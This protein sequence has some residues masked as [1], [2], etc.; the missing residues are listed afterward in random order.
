VDVALKQRPPEGRVELDELT[1]ERA[2]RG[3]RAAFRALVFHHQRAVFALLSRMLARR[4]SQALVEDLAQ[5]TFVRVFRALPTFG[6]DG[7]HNLSGWILTIAARL[8]LDELRRPAPATE[9]LDRIADV[10]AGARVDQAVERHALRS[11][12]ERA[13][14]QLP[15]P[16]RATFLLRE[17]HGLPYEEIAEALAVD[18]GTV[19][20]RLNRARTVLRAALTGILDEP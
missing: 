15:P 11:A 9:P 3:D 20:S 1:V 17:L 16:Y 14:E 6:D 4:G 8:A 18:L 7:R 12:L 5:E 13:V 19:K 10:A 2:K